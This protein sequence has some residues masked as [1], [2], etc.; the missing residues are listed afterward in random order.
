[1]SRNIIKQYCTEGIPIYIYIYL[2][3]NV[4]IYFKSLSYGLIKYLKILKIRKKKELWK[5][6]K[7]YSL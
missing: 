7:G 1:M 2:E 5:W 6:L 3:F 4:K